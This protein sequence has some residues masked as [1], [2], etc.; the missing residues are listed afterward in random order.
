ML[1][2]DEKMYVIKRNNERVPIKFDS[3]TR[4]NEKIV[5]ELNLNIDCAKLSMK[6]INSL[7]SSMKTSEI[8]N[9]SAEEAYYLS[10]RNPDYGKLASYI[11]ISNHQKQC[12]KTFKEC[13]EQLYNNYD[14]D[15]KKPIPL[16][17]TDVYDFAM[18]HIDRIEKEIDR[19]RDFKYD[20]F[21]FKTLQKSYLLPFN[22]KKIIETPQYM[23]MRVF[24]GIFGK[25][26]R[27]VKLCKK[28]QKY[29]VNKCKLNIYIRNRKDS[30]ILKMTISDWNKIILPHKYNEN[31]SN[32]DE[33]LI[34]KTIKISNK[35]M[36]YIKKLTDPL[37][38]DIEKVIDRYHIAS[39]HYFTPASPTLFNSGTNFPQM[40]SCFLISVPDDLEQM[41]KFLEKI[42]KISAKAGGIG[43][44]LSLI[45]AKGSKIGSTQSEASGIIPYLRL[46]DN[47]CIQVSQGR[48][49]GSF[50]TYLQPHHPEIME[51]LQVRLPNCS[52]EL[53]CPNIFT[54][55]YS[56]DLFFERMENDEMWSLFCPSK[57]NLTDVYGKEYREKYLE[58]EKNKLYNKQ[59]KAREVYEALVYSRQKC[60]TPYLLNKD[61]INE[62]NAQKN[63][64]TIR[65]SNLCTE[66]LEYTDGENI[67][68]CNLT[69]IALPMF[70]KKCNYKYLDSNE[71]VKEKNNILNSNL[72]NIILGYLPKNELYFDF[73]YLGKIVEMCVENCDRIIDINL[74]PVKETKR[75]NTS[76]RPIGIGVQ[77]LSDVYK[78]LRYSWE[79]QKAKDLNKSIFSTIY[80]HFLKKTNE[81]GIKYGSYPRFKGSPASEGILQYHMWKQEPDTSVISKK[82]WNEIEVNI[83]KGMRNSLGIALMP[84]ASTSQILGNIESIEVSTYNIYTRGTLAGNFYYVDKHLYKELVKLNMWNTE[85]INKIIKDRG[86]VQNLN[87][88]DE[89]KE[90][91]K[92]VWEL[93]QKHVIDQSADRGPY[94]DQTQSL[95][96][97][98]EKPTLG[99]LSTMDLYSW[100]KGL[101]TLAYYTRSKSAMDSTMFTIMEDTVKDK[102]TK[103]EEKE[104]PQVCYKGCETCSS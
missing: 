46:L 77:G 18:K 37:E 83:K 79:N 17:S 25:H 65:L 98:V 96:I 81:L 102:F 82:Q 55:F 13:I 93:S 87:I 85:T 67:A 90:I 56:N 78:M 75:A 100:K 66:I 57:L 104:E 7:K 20:Y 22:S 34:D 92:T 6:V 72:T 70:V 23:L 94:I 15:Q 8:D 9:L 27:K 84:T 41:Y 38:G 19:S 2:D 30:E 97:H 60:G 99:K 3:I 40:A 14:E 5:K 64:G 50:A 54:A 47:S 28:L 39:E 45:R 11:A 48:R 12:P 31:K 32:N 49:K 71:N 42:A 33:T 53:R 68:V 35:I 76:Q 43:V 36:K 16:I 52:D 63:I 59:I 26:T 21:G 103:K 29:I 91:Y 80:Y 86:S 69:S 4:R 101:K 44:D 51:F 10:S 74:Y 1:S 62:K 89:L 88:S 95:N 24:L 73:D 58:G 61:A